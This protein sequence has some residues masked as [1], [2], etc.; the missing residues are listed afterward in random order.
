MSKE[1]VNRIVQI[2]E[3]LQEMHDGAI[4]ESEAICNITA[5]IEDAYAHYIDPKTDKEV[6]LFE[7]DN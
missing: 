2:R 1:P 4:C 7:E 5:V 3:V 6:S